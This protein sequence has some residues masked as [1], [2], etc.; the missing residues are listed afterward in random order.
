MQLKD[1]QLVAVEAML[2]QAV[3]LLTLS[4]PY[5]PKAHRGF[6]R[7]ASPVGSGK[8]VMA[9]AFLGAFLKR[10]PQWSVLWLSPAQG[11]L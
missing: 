6:A 4:D 3:E 5:K 10:N 7:L 8:T 9:A 11:G 2:D 1:Y